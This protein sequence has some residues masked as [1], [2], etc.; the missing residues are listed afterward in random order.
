MPNQ[1][2]ILITGAAGFLG[3]HIVEA[4]LDQGHV[5]DFLDNFLHN[6][7]PDLKRQNAAEVA[8]SR[9]GLLDVHEVDLRDTSAISVLMATLRPNLIVH[10]AAVAG[11]SPSLDHPA[12]YAEHN[13]IATIN[14]LEAMRAVGCQKLVFASSSSV[15][16][17]DS[18]VPFVEN[19]PALR[20]ASPYAA[21]KRSAELYL[22]TYADLYGLDFLALRFFTVYGPRQRPDLAI[23]KF[24]RAILTGQP[25]T[26]NGD[27]TSSRDY[28]HVTDIVAGVM[29]SIEY[30]SENNN[31]R[32]VVNL[33]SSSPVLLRDLIA[34]IEKACDR[35]AVVERRPE[36]LG[37]VPRTYA[38]VNKAR[39]LFGYEPRR[40]L[41]EG[42][43]EFVEWWRG[44]FL[45]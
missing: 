37:D 41:I 18:A 38:D 33:G 1:Q 11:V 45:S 19:A 31:V 17:S 10:C 9:P 42:V 3:S 39:H 20:P 24:T 12:W 29:R 22:Y 32:E 8:A 4:C 44:R 43:E 16:G 7:D 36:Q 13:V 6:Y 14:L 15:Y 30:V 2:R 23:H 34:I 26:I 5:V 28:T 35:E 21:S 25:I 40:E 27:G